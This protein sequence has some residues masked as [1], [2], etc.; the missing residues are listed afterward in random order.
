M[1]EYYFAF[2]IRK[3]QKILCR[4]YFTGEDVGSRIRQNVSSEDDGHEG[5]NSDRSMKVHDRSSV[6]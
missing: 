5:C 4:E 3:D 2:S 1:T 6:V